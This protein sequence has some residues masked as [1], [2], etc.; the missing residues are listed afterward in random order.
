MNWLNV[1]YI[2][3]AFVTKNNIILLFN[4]PNYTAKHCRNSKLIALKFFSSG[5]FDF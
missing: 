3:D 1:T 5:N 4:A 2:L